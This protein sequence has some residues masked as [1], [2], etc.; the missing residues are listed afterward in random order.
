M[1]TDPILYG[2]L[3]CVFR[4]GQDGA[5]ITKLEAAE[6]ALEHKNDQ[7]AR[8]CLKDLGEMIQISFTNKVI[9]YASWCSRS[10]QACGKVNILKVP[11]FIRDLLPDG[12]PPLPEDC[13]WHFFISK[14]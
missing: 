10:H 11:H 2:S 7:L 1:V 13:Q 4:S 5:M 14:Q 9:N 8:A 3:I 12:I 6:S